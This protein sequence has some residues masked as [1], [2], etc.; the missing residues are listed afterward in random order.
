[1]KF[2]RD[3]FTYSHLV[4][5]SA[6]AFLKLYQEESSL[7]SIDLKNQAY[8]VIYSRISAKEPIEFKIQNDKLDLSLENR[9]VTTAL[10]DFLKNGLS[11]ET[12]EIVKNYLADKIKKSISDQISLT[13]LRNLILFS[14]AIESANNHYFNQ[15]KEI[16]TIKLLEELC[17]KNETLIEESGLKEMARLMYSIKVNDL[18]EVNP[19][20]VDDLGIEALIELSISD[21]LISD[22]FSRNDQAK[23]N[24][25]EP[26]QIRRLLYL[27]KVSDEVSLMNV[28]NGLKEPTPK[29]I[30]SV[31]V[32]SIILYLLKYNES[33]SLAK[34]ESFE[35]L[36]DI[37]KFGFRGIELNE[38]KRSLLTFT[39]YFKV[40]NII[41]GKLW[42]I[43]LHWVLLINLFGWGAISLYL[44][45]TIVEGVQ[46]FSWVE[47]ASIV[48]IIVFDVSLIFEALK[49]WRHKY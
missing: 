33:I 32:N 37:G 11:S 47:I 10:E 36:D 40:P 42:G 39:P 21:F 26:Y 22:K 43:P 46:F 5:Q 17:E 23:R 16:L 13:N 48:I 41:E 14:F 25:I 45:L 3:Q 4:L 15:D 29:L 12:I 20:P 30:T 1:M 44:T 35:Y 49:K 34:F 9:L 19:V 6:E 28:L 24:L 2:G 27:K 18:K 8:M 31:F 7:T 38:E